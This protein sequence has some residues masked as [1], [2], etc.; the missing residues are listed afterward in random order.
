MT[1]EI[2]VRSATAGDA[3]AI[4]AIYN[5]AIAERTSTFETQPRCAADISGTLHASSQIG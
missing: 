5:A 2:E 4:C 3:E 1:R